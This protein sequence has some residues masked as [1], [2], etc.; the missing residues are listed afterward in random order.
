M[1]Y[2]H[3]IAALSL[4]GLLVGCGRLPLDTHTT[5]SRNGSSG[6]AAAA[7]GVALNSYAALGPN[8]L[9]LKVLA[10][11]GRDMTL[12]QVKGQ[13][14]DYLEVN[15]TL[16]TGAISANPYTIIPS[17]LE[18]VPYFMAVEAL[19]S[20]VAANYASALQAG[21]QGVV[22]NDCRQQ[23]GAA[24]I[25]LVNYPEANSAEQASI[26]QDIVT[27]CTTDGIAPTVEAIVKSYAFLVKSET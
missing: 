4:L 7:N 3:G 2:T 19:G 11:F 22:A 12:Y 14:V 6:D 9:A 27:A 5:D 8:D 13:A 21:T 26:A 16:F 18:S 1:S 17:A 23:D 25:V 20:I 15:G 24:A 10:A